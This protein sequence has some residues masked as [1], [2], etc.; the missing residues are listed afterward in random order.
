M[1]HKDLYITCA[2]GVIITAVCTLLLNGMIVGAF[3]ILPSSLQKK[4]PNVMAVNQACANISSVVPSLLIS[5][6]VFLL[7]GEPRVFKPKLH[8]M[9]WVFFLYTNFL[10]ILSL[11]LST[12]DRFINVKFPGRY[13]KTAS[14][15]KAVVLVL[16]A[17]MVSLVPPVLYDDAAANGKD[18]YP[19]FRVIFTL[20]L[21]LTAVV[22][23]LLSV[24]YINLR[25]EFHQQIEA[26]LS[27][28]GP[29]CTNDEEHKQQMANE[30]RLV[31]VL[32]ARTCTYMCTLLPHIVLRLI[33]LHREALKVHHSIRYWLSVTYFVYSFNGVLD[34]LLTMFLRADFHR[35]R[36]WVTF[37]RCSRTSG[38]VERGYDETVIVTDEV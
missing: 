22:L 7:L 26:K 35:A 32:F 20:L 11:L 30:R 1:Q 17:W 2:I 8:Q 34:P 37:G 28:S 15:G 19:V 33:V 18:I 24:T 36:S 16:V 9:Y 4:V 10:V 13:H 3:I 6:V 12:V 38:A 21:V 31:C 29:D 25:S 5:T 27:L 14:V 23:I